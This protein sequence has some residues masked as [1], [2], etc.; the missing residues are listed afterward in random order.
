MLIAPTGIRCCVIKENEFGVVTLS[1]KKL[2]L[3]I[4]CRMGLSATPY[5]PN[6]PQ[7]LDNYFKNIVYEYS[8]KDFL[9]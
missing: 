7:L 8:I 1:I 2:P 3:N 4:N 6:E 5:E 9:I